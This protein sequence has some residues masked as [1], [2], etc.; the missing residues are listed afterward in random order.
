MVSV[1]IDTTSLR[2]KTKKGPSKLHPLIIQLIY[3]FSSS[4]LCTD[5]ICFLQPFLKWLRSVI[6][7]KNKKRFSKYS[8]WE[9]PNDFLITN[10]ASKSDKDKKM[11][12][13]KWQISLDL[14][15]TEK[16]GKLDLSQGVLYAWGVN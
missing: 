11:P 2:S 6:C 16:I 5:V 9:D 10:I 8:D 12:V 4:L 15:I 3:L 14:G 1:H 7:S 13:E